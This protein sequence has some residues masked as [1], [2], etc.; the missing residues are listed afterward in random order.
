MGNDPSSQGPR[1]RRR[2]SHWDGTE[3]IESSFGHDEILVGCSGRKVKEEARETDPELRRKISQEIRTWESQTWL[4]STMGIM[5]T[6][7]GGAGDTRAENRTQGGGV[8]G[9]DMRQHPWDKP[10]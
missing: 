7:Q 8:E 1:Q 9:T 6:S 5:S 2:S 3:G 10:G 4:P